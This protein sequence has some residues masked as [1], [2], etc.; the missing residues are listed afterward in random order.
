MIWYILALVGLIFVYVWVS[1]LEKK[2][3]EKVLLRL[4]L[5]AGVVTFLEGKV[6]Y[7]LE[8]GEDKDL[9]RSRFPL[10]LKLYF[11]DFDF[12]STKDYSLKID[13]SEYNVYAFGK[14]Y[15]YIDLPVNAEVTILVTDKREK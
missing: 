4:T 10:T 11:K 1:K 14:D 8:I 7:E 9:S 15:S 12:K 3:E 2:V 6:P 5:K 13:G